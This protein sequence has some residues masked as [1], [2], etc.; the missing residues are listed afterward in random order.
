VGEM[1]SRVNDAWSDL[2]V[3]PEMTTPHGR[4]GARQLSGADQEQLHAAV[5]EARAQA[6]ALRR[7]VDDAEAVLQRCRELLD[8][9]RSI[10]AYPTAYRW[11]EGPVHLT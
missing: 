5:E 3:V 8:S 11:P 4:M 2:Y 7:A 9:L 10:L 1:S 6:V